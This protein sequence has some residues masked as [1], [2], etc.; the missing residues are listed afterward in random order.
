MIATGIVT[1]LTWSCDGKHQPQSAVV[2]SFTNS[3]LLTLE[4]YPMDVTPHLVLVCLQK[5]TVPI[6]HRVTNQSLVPLR[7]LNQTQL[8]NITRQ[9]CP[10]L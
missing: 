8:E 4:D 2:T 10:E 3:T 5:N 6:L 9:Y 1:Q 7:D